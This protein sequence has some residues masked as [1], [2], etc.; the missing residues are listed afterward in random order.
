MLRRI[1]EIYGDRI[2]WSFF[3]IC[4]PLFTILTISLAWLHTE[5]HL[6]HMYD[7]RALVKHDRVV[8]IITLPSFYALMSLASCVPLFKLS[9]G[10]ED[11]AD[12]E[13]PFGGPADT[14]QR[15]PGETPE[16]V[17]VWRY[18]TCSFM[19]AMFEAWTIYQF[20]TL[21]L[22]QVGDA[23]KSRLK[24]LKVVDDSD[25]AELRDE[26]V[27]AHKGMSRLAMVGTSLYFLNCIAQS[28]TAISVYFG[29]HNGEK[30]QLSGTLHNA[31]LITET[32]ALWSIV[33]A[34]MTYRRH[35]GPM[36]P[37][38]KFAMIEF[39]ITM[40]IMQRQLLEWMIQFNGILPV[41]VQHIVQY[42]PLIGE[43]VT[44]KSGEMNLFC[45]VLLIMESMVLMLLNTEIW[46]ANEAWYEEA[47][48]KKLPR[49]PTQADCV[50]M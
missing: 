14:P 8:N 3:L 23:I 49:A 2:G 9:S 50:E 47:D 40:N 24:R 36:D 25:V 41:E 46:D 19:S 39:M 38:N 29:V 42:I 20:G 43:I 44:M 12:F 16:M 21:I 22:D 26:L 5:R 28:A 11:I 1:T 27:D 32:V 30:A 48:I 7:G 17:A 34:W 31:T 37:A 6:Y 13:S 18:Q 10:R 45:A 35:L 4:A 33:V 15:F